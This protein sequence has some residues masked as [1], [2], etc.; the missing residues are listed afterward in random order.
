MTAEEWQKDI[1]KDPDYKLVGD[2]WFEMVG[3]TKNFPTSLYR[4]ASNQNVEDAYNRHI[5]YMSGLISPRRSGVSTPNPCLSGDEPLDWGTDEDKYVTCS[6]QSYGAYPLL[7]SDHPPRSTRDGS[8]D[9]GHLVHNV[10]PKVGLL[11]ALDVLDCEHGELFSHC[12]KCRVKLSS[13]W[14]LDSGASAHFTNNLSDFVSYTPASP[15]NR[16]PVRT[17]AHTIYVE[18]EG[19]ILLKHLLNGTQVTTRVHPVLY[20]PS[21]STRLLS[22]GEFLQQGMRVLGNSQQI[23]LSYDSQPL[24][25]CKPLVHGHNLFWLD[26]TPTVIESQYSET[27]NI[28]KVD[29]DLMHRRLGHPSKDVLRHAKEH[30]RGFPKGIIIPTDSGICPGCAQGKMPAASHPPSSSRATKPFERIHSDLKSFPIESYHKYKYFVVFFDD[31][32]SYAWITLLRN[33]A[34]AI[35]ALK[36]WMALVKTKYSATIKEWMSDAGGE[37]KS[38][39]FIKELKDNGITIL[40]SA[41]HTP[42]QNGRAERFMRTI[43]DKAQ[44]MRLEACIPQ[45]WWEFAVSHAAHCYNRTPLARLKWQT[46]FFLLNN[47]SP[48]ISYLR[49]FGCGAYVHIPEA[50]RVNKLS[51]KSELMI[52]LGRQSGMKADTFMRN[53]NTLF[54]SDKALFDELLYPS[55]SLEKRPPRVTRINEPRSNQPPNDEDTTPGDLDLPPPELPKGSGAPKSGGTKGKGKSTQTPILP[56]ALPPV[57]APVPG[58]STEPRRSGRLRKQATRPDNVYGKGDPVQITRDIERTRTWRNLVDDQPGS[59]RVRSSQGR[60]VPGSTPEQAESDPPSANDEDPHESEDEVDQLVLARL[61][62]EGGVKFLDLLLAKAISPD[63]PG[64]PDTSNIREWTYR[65][66]LRMPRDQQEEWR[67][68]CREELESLRKRKVFELVDPLK[69]RKVIKNRWVFDLKSDG[70]RK[71]RLVAKG[72]SQVEGVDYDEIFSPVVRYETV[73]MMI[74][75]AALKDWHISGLDV[76]TAFLYGELDEELYMEQPEGF[77][78]PGQQHKVLRLKRAIY[79]LKQAALAWWKALDKSMAALGCTRLLTDSGLFVN[80]EKNI[81]IIVYVDDVLFLGSDKNKIHSL[82]QRFMKIWECRDLGDTQEFLRMRIVKTKGRILVDQKTYLQ[83]VLQ[84][85]KLLNA[86][87]APTPL[88]EGYL[89]QP[90]KGPINPELRASFQQVIGSLLYIML[91]TRPDIAFAVTKLS[92]FAANPTE[93][94]LNRALYVCRYLLGTADYALVYDGKSNGGLVAYADSDWASDPNT[95][96]STTGYLVKLANGVFSWNSRAQKSI[97]LSSTEAEYMSLS[98]TS[99][100]LVWIRTLFQEIGISLGPIPLCGDN[101][102]S[103][104]LASNPVQEKRIKHIDLRYHYIREIIRQK[105]IELL[106]IEGAE[107][108]ADLFTKNLGRIKFL[109]FREQLGLEFYPPAL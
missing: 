92:Q 57:P 8:F 84:R 12:A 97:A 24:V 27:P 109:K 3:N 89:P 58:P 69:G 38:D 79:G 91:G 26:A 33:K 39:A 55:C 52:Y 40:Q 1:E 46:P 68:A 86:K 19:T 37:Y 64:S 42:Q 21:M 67:N 48:D 74:A 4:S 56:P 62:Q 90:N 75:L 53:H 96:K 36:Q 17:A 32:T 7:A 108:P 70:W 98:D 23:T 63:D 65:D 88:P 49:V 104:F 61:A 77:K 106:F 5:E 87:A 71:A 13:M 76:K 54:Y 100:Q 60:P 81:V 95:R 34:S 22:M 45:S 73:R 9:A 82:K 30:T 80:K 25:Q 105:Q 72:F 29:Y 78:L 99:R 6:N 101:Q 103:I 28:Y 20:I 2:I 10:L 102:G 94:H 59:S 107:N 35:T 93:D 51:P 14:L 43:M 83:K 66:I 16:T 47:E 15:S 50:R 31:Y 41:P 18:G 85:F 44:A 11:N